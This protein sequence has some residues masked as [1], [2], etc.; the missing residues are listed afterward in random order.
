MGRGDDRAIEICRDE[1]RRQAQS[2]FGRSDIDFGDMHVDDNSGRRDSIRGEFSLGRNRGRDN[3]HDFVCSVNLDAGRVRRVVID[4]GG[5]RGGPGNSYRDGD[6]DGNRGGMANA[7]QNCQREVDQRLRRNGYG[8]VAFDR[9]AIDNRP[10]RNDQVVGVANVR[11]RN[12]IGAAGVQLP[13]GFE[14]R[15][16]A[17]GGFGPRPAVLNA[18]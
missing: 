7:V 13:S 11:G 18:H 17:V 12:G 15:R 2:M 1:V 14:R 16:R 5:R 3:S 9:I 10:G 8:D 6:R 4:P